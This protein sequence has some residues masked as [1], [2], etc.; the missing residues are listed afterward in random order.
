M[1]VRHSCSRR[2]PRK[3]FPRQEASIKKMFLAAIMA[4]LAAV[5][6]ARGAEMKRLTLA[7]AVELALKQN[8]ALKIARLQV[9]ENQEDKASAKSL[10]F[11]TLYNDTR[12]EFPSWYTTS[13]P[14]V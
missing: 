3:R 14:L 13:A 4:A 7:E 8:R 11:P 10:Y 1:K 2:Q 5:S 6:A 9:Q 12:T